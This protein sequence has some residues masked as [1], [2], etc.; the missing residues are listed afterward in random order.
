MEKE[1]PDIYPGF[2]GL[3]TE[4]ALEILPEDKAREA[5]P[6][7]VLLQHVRTASRTATQ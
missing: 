1:I 4:M 7:S 2:W 6:R 5:S 3:S